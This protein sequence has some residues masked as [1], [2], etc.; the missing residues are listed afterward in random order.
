MNENTTINVGQKG[1]L[2]IGWLFNLDIVYCGMPN[3]NTFS[4]S[5][6]E[7]SGNKGIG[8]NLFFPKDTKQMTLA[9]NEVRVID[10]SKEHLIVQLVERR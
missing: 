7:H 1:K 9:G 8:M 6:M 2:K 5:Y 3:E 10:V 4:V